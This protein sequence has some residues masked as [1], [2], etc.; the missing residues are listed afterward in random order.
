MIH[1]PSSPKLELTISPERY[2]A[3]VSSCLRRINFEIPS[4]DLD[5]NLEA[6]IFEY[7]ESQPWPAD[8]QTRCMKLAG[9]L[10]T[11]M[12]YMHPMVSLQNRVYH[13]IYGTLTVLYDDELEREKAANAGAV[14]EL[15]DFTAGLIRGERQRNPV[16]ESLAE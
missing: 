10:A 6:P 3:M 1:S 5:Y 7:I 2:Q 13:G 11:G 14:D 9:Y 4:H 12:G 8:V 15:G 16:L